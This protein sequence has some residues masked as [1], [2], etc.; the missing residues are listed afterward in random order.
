MI[1]M[2]AVLALFLTAVLA[3]ADT[4]LP[5]DPKRSS[6]PNLNLLDPVK[7][8]LSGRPWLMI[9]GIDPGLA[10]RP[11]WDP[12]TRLDW[13]QLGSG[14]MTGSM[15]PSLQAAG[16][17][18][19][20]FR[21]PA[22]AFSRDILISRDFSSTPIQTEPH[23]AIDPDDPD[24]VVV[25]MIDYN[26]PSITNYVTF[27]GGTRWEGPFQGGYL[28]DDMVSGGDPV[29]A[30][31]RQG[32]LYMA[33]ISIGVEEFTVRP[34]ST[35]TIV[36]SIA[37]ARSTDGGFSWPT[38][39]ST[40]RSSVKLSEQ[41]LDASGRLR[42][43]VA[44]GFL[45][46]PWLTVGPHPNDRS[47]DVIYMSYTDFEIFYTIL[48]T[49]EL[50]LL[51]AREMAS[52]IRLVR[53]EDQ[54]MTW[55]DPFA[56]SPTVRRVFGAVDSPADTPGM[57]GS[58]R[59]VQGSRP[60]VDKNGH[61]YVAWLD[62]TDDGSMEGLGELVV[63]RS[64][65]AGKT[66]AT[67]T[68]VTVFNEV[69]FRPRNA[70][71][72]YW[73][74]AFPKM[75]AGPRGELYIVYAGRPSEKL[76]DDGDIFFIRSVDRGRSWSSPVRLNDD[77]GDGLQFFPEIDVGPDGAIHVMWGDMRDDP[78]QIR[79]HIYYTQST[80]RGF[81]WGFEA[82]EFGFRTRD[83]RVT[84]FP[85]NPNRGFP[86]GLFIGD[87]F[88][89]AAGEDV[90]MVWADSRLGEFGGTNQKIGFARQRAI[91]KPDIFVSPSAGPGGQSI[92]VQGF[93]FQPDMN[94]MVQLQDATIAIARTNQ[95]GRFTTGIYVPVTGE[96]AQ[97]L[98]V[99][100]ESGNFAATSFYTEFGFNNIEQLYDDLLREIQDLSRNLESNP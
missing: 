52:T 53:S 19:V 49:G 59:V 40:D 68:I 18:L 74:S 46:K 39:V 6:G 96:G 10:R 43:T 8:H 88:S 56:V 9:E 41:Q 67:P 38:I 72:R 92:T 89:L 3:K 69:P 7:T 87:Y 80:D 79:Y 83:T 2:L 29:L 37:M 93:N 77:D 47:R 66:F 84:D 35:S 20:P 86:F 73:A 51:L 48:Y 22:P 62:S 31:D 13:R 63:A 100:D 82:E 54:G 4:K 75:A 1:A 98:R 95:E 30:F 97:T 65:D 42:G 23:I 57:F 5:V 12:L 71:F 26:F 16:G 32:N 25:A 17:F 60:V 76:R 91:R 14:G 24:H 11:G 78:V 81:T 28:P 15:S 44:V 21:S 99:F 85:S 64:T 70:F 61:V 90:Y 50:P 36:S 33:S 34:I 45:D 58:D 27:D 55:S 94:V